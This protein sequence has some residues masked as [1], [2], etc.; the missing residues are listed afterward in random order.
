ML[1][2]LFRETVSVQSLVGQRATWHVISRYYNIGR[3]CQ[4]SIVCS[5]YIHYTNSTSKTVAG[6]HN[7]VG[8]CWTEALCI[9]EQLLSSDLKALQYRRVDESEIDIVILPN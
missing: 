1:K 2:V 4:S 7:K 6:L 8:C 9:V 5:I 3:G